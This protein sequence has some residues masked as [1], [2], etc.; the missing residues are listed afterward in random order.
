MFLITQ[1]FLILSI[2]KN[3]K[4][5]YLPIADIHGIIRDKWIQMD[6]SEKCGFAANPSTV[7]AT[8]MIKK[9][10][11]KVVQM[12]DLATCLLL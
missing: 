12:A 7:P 9:D 11:L 5:I 4:T 3:N 10:Y 1:D 8:K 2:T 6:Y